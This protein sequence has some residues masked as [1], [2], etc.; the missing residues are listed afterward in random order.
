MAVTLFSSQ[1]IA[2]ASFVLSTDFADWA[3]L[4]PD[5]LVIVASDRVGAIGTWAGGGFTQLSYINNFK[6]LGVMAGFVSDLNGAT[7]YS[8][9]TGSS[10]KIF[11]LRGVDPT[12][13]LSTLGAASNFYYNENPLTFGTVNVPSA[14]GSVV[15]SLKSC[16]N[17]N[18][19]DYATLTIGS[20]LATGGQLFSTTN[21]RFGLWDN[22]ETGSKLIT[23]TPP[24]GGG[25]AGDSIYSTFG[26]E[27][28][29]DTQTFSIGQIDAATLQGFDLETEALGLFPGGLGDG[30]SINGFGLVTEQTFTFGQVAAGVVN[31]F[32]LDL[33]VPQTLLIGGLGDAATVH[34][35]DF[36]SVGVGPPV[37]FTTPSAPSP[38]CGE[39]SLV[40]T[41]RRTRQAIVKL[42]AIATSGHWARVH[43]DTS[44]AAVQINLPEAGRTCQ[45]QLADVHVLGHELRINRQR[46]DGR[47]D[48]VWVGPITS[49]IVDNGVL[50]LV[51]QD[52]SH[53]WQRAIETDHIYGSD[54]PIDIAALFVAVAMDADIYDPTGLLLTSSATGIKGTAS[55]LKAQRW[56]IRYFID[57]LT[58]IAVDWTIQGRLTW[59]GG[60]QL[61]PEVMGVLNSGDFAENQ[62]PEN[63]EDGLA[64]AG[65]IIVRGANGIVLAIYPEDP[66]AA[67][68]PFYGLRDYELN[69]RKLT[70]VNLAR[71]RAKAIWEKRHL[72]PNYVTCGPNSTLSAKAP[73]DVGGLIP[74][75]KWN[76]A[77][78]DLAG[79]SSQTTQRLTAV[80]VEFGPG[81]NLCQETAVRVSFE[82]PGS[83]VAFDV[84]KLV[85]VTNP[86]G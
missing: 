35:F 50:S 81:E 78:F 12:I 20:T 55:I 60:Q 6:S 47:P 18:D 44:A 54:N 59:I 1:T 43:G 21:F 3:S 19:N 64:W 56:P 24:G 46:S 69:D 33:V 31:G 84:I 68:D 17:N 2:A 36:E 37:R 62:A 4:L 9:T 52:R 80:T 71:A 14:A 27:A 57:Q 34:G 30:A 72:Q 42:P 13:D 5:D 11:A 76:L 77:T 51:A 65:R 70:D 15:A 39:Y 83:E 75:Q 22:V 45:T 58:K 16:Y 8:F 53:Y 74:G 85:E 86:S 7:S 49:R 10:Y 41:D 73:V 82:P 25:G 61:F 40:I 28:A 23:V 26:L 66:L 38:L 29:D 48:E 63:E 67:V 79:R 32:D